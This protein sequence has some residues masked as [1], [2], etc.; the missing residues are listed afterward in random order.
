MKQRDHEQKERRPRNVED[1]RRRRRGQ[2]PR[3]RRQRLRPRRGSAAPGRIRIG[4]EGHLEGHGIEP[5]LKRARNPAQRPRAQTV[6]KPHRR[7]E[8]DRKKRERDQRLDRSR[9]QHA[10]IDLQHV[11]RTGK[12]QDVHHR[13]EQRHRNQSAPHLCPRARQFR[14][15]RAIRP[16]HVV[17]LSVPCEATLRPES[18][19][20]HLRPQAR[21]A[22]SG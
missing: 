20:V 22:F 15:C 6:Q 14:L 21:A 19:A 16:V 12:H 10:V 13:A 7:I 9:A 5:G 18:L 4:I 17:R 2:P 1:R 3:H 11:K 8:E